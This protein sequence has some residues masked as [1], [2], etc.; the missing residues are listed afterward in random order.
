MKRKSGRERGDHQQLIYGV[1]PIVEALRSGRAPREIII[2]E[3]ARDD[4]LRE[5]MA[6]AKEHGVRVR[7][8]PKSELDRDAG[9]SHHQG[10][11]AHVA[12]PTYTDAD[13]LL[14]SLNA[15]ASREPLMMV[16]DGVE[17]PRNLGA[18][19]RTAEC[20]GADGV[21]IP[22]R[23]AAGLNETVAKASAG[24]VAHLPVARVTNLSVLIRQLKE[25]NLWVV[26]TAADAPLDYTAW[27]W[28][29]PS[30]I[31]LGGEGAGLHRLVRENCDALVRIPVYGRIESLNVSVTA[32]IV[33]YEAVR[34]RLMQ[35]QNSG[36]G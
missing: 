31:V 24:A 34:Q 10:V 4:R 19:L 3:G 36:G 6:L 5:L 17:D 9:N 11:I 23:R 22:E 28:T 20:A 18:I 14:D 26:G 15:G 8:L 29:R 32:G 25:R 27:D 7:R 16:L 13:E 12:A 2:A 1:N 30:V 33:L 21:F 35:K